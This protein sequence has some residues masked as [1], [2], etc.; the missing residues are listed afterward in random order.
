MVTTA[1]HCTI[2]GYSQILWP[3]QPN[4][5]LYPDTARSC[6]HYSQTLYYIRI[7][8]DPVFTTAKHCTISGYSQI[9]C[10]LQPNTVLYPDT[11]RSYG[12]YSQTLNP[13]RIQPDPVFTTAKQCTLYGYSQILCS[14][15]PHNAPCLDTAISLSPPEYQCPMYFLC[16]PKSPS[17]VPTKILYSFLTSAVFAIPQ[18]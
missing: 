11:A 12:H 2:S 10:S 5:V 9:L 14:L 18:P 6:V 7:Q 17:N 4:T 16:L 13:V 3:L 15:Q 1:K 8:P